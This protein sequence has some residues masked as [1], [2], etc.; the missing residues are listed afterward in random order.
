MSCRT[1][2]VGGKIV[3]PVA[4]SRVASVCT[5]AGQA[6]LDTITTAPDT[7]LGA[8]NWDF[9]ACCAGWCIWSSQWPSRSR[10]GQGICDGLVSSLWEWQEAHPAAAID[11]QIVSPK[12]TLSGWCDATGACSTETVDADDSRSEPH[13]EARPDTLR[14]QAIARICNSADGGGMSMVEWRRVRRAW[15]PGRHYANQHNRT[16][17]SF[18]EVVWFHPINQQTTCH[19]EAQVVYRP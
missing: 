16:S 13:D 11:L 1:C 5:Q 10:I 3:S 18:C 8:G 14:R 9:L 7:V 6:T 12:E 15:Y 17:H 4:K 19:V 2:V